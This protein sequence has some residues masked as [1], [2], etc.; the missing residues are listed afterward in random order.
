MSDPG[1]MN[2]TLH[3]LTC[4]YDQTQGE[5]EALAGTALHRP[6]L[7]LKFQNEIITDGD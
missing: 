7:L 5:K 4:A 6:Y 2:K 3:G 1:E